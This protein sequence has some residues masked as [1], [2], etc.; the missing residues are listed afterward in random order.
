M[1]RCELCDY[2]TKIKANYLKHTTSKKHKR[3]CE[4]NLATNKAT[5]QQP[6]T[7]QELAGVSQKL[8]KVSQPLASR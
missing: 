2:E 7:I 6:V 1:Y 3:M 8:A 5:I 4:N